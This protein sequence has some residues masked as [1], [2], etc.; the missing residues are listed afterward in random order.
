ME[1]DLDMAFTV[2]YAIVLFSIALSLY[3]ISSDVPTAVQTVP[4]TGEQVQQ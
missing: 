2:Y 3:G 1:F 4:Q